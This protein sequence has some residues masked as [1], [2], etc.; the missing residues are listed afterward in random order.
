VADYLM[1]VRMFILFWLRSWPGEPVPRMCD[2]PAK[3][4]FCRLAIVV[5]TTVGTTE[6]ILSKPEPSIKDA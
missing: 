5:L 3:I 2:L 1:F 6:Q 4:I